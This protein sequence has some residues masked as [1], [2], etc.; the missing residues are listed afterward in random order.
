[1]GRKSG[2]TPL[3]NSDMFIEIIRLD[4][5]SQILLR[6]IQSTLSSS[7][8][9]KSYL[10]QN[11]HQFEKRENMSGFSMLETIKLL[12]KFIFGHV[13]LFWTEPLLNSLRLHWDIRILRRV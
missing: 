5:F 9:P 3:M 13:K 10:V 2:V 4:Y 12:L 7:S 11:R 8:Q 1:M 6:Q